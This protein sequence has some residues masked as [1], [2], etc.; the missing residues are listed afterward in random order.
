VVAKRLS[1][2]YPDVEKDVSFSA[3]PEK[4]ARPEPDPDNTMLAVSLAFS[5]L[6]GLVLLVACFNITNVLLVRAT[7]RQRETAIRAALGA[8]RRRLLMQYLTES[9]L[10]SLLGGAAGWLLAIWAAGFLSSLPLG[11]DLPIVFDFQ[12]D[13]RVGVFALGVVLLTGLVVGIIPAL[14]MARS[15][16]NSILREGGRGMSDGRGR[17]IVRN[18]LVVAQLAGS[19]LLLVVAGLFV[20]SLGKIQQTDFGFN[21]DHVMNFSVDVQQAA[22]K[23]VQGKEFYRQIDESIRALPGVVSTGQAFT[24]PMGYIS[25]FDAVYVEGR[26]LQ[27][28]EQP[29]SVG[30]NT[31]SPG[32][33]ATLQIPLHRGRVFTEAD[34]EKAPKVAVINES[35]AKKFW[36]DSDAVGKRFSTSDPTHPPIEVVGVVQ[37]GKYTNLMEPS[38]QPFFYLPLLQNYMPLRTIHVR[39]AGPPENIALQIE[40]RIHELAPN[41]PVSKQT[42][43]QS[44]GGINGMLFFR[45][46]AQLTATMGLLGLILAVVGVYSVVSYTAAQRTHEIGIRMALGAAPGDILQMVLRESVWIV[47]IGLAVGLLVALGGTRAI[48]DLFVGIHPTDPVTFVTTALLLSAVALTACWIPARRATR[49]SPLTALRY[50]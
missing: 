15:D 43:V 20:R 45:L 3:Y 18:A 25:S 47:A 14:R 34:G 27:P 39:T 19:L 48:A 36:P 26:P 31:V 44:L 22:L 42:M 37:D 49:V 32:Y 35:M 1:E 5:I 33:F 30:N 13:W 9:L 11:T 41:L 24:V 28:G 46:A 8:G 50:E 4:L 40:T 21:P 17:H 2:Q 29:P 7:V 38:T 6:A 10:L 23:E 12:P 16:V